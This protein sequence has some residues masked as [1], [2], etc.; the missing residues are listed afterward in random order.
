MNLY[1]LVNEM[2]KKKKKGKLG[3]AG[4]AFISKFE[5]S[6]KES[7][8]ALDEMKLREYGNLVIHAIPSAVKKLK[9]VA[10]DDEVRAA[11]YMVAEKYIKMLTP[12]V[13]HMAEELWAKF[14]GKGFVSE[15]DWPKY[16]KKLIDEKFL[17]YEELSD[18]IAEDIRSVIKLVTFK[19]KIV[20]IYVSPKWKYPF[21]K[22]L[23][24]EI[25]KTRDIGAI[26]KKVMDKKHGIEISKLV[27][28]I[29]K[30]PSKLPSVV[31]DQV[32]EYKSLSEISDFLSK[33]FNCKIEVIEAE[34][35]KSGK[36]QKAGPGKPGI[37]LE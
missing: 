31:L 37:E 25:E 5:N 26:M 20:R 11:Y 14:G 13:P 3:S 15:A 10:S 36:A 32:S 4:N 34:D 28:Y 8:E 24:E 6:L 12:V 7:S 35:S 23:K 22:K 2:I 19:P 9:R 27:P 18:K 30:D 16:D 1:K 17:A 33:E 29:V 21:F